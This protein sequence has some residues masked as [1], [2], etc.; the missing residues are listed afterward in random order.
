MGVSQWKCTQTYV[1]WS[2]TH[3]EVVVDFQGNLPVKFGLES[4]SRLSDDINVIG[5]FDLLT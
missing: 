4:R 2:I 3:V 5:N 1:G